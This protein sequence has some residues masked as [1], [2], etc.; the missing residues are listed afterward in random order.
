MRKTRAVRLLSALMPEEQKEFKRY[1]S[2]P[3]FN[4]SSRQI[5]ATTLLLK[6]INVPD[7]LLNKSEL[8]LKLFPDLKN[9]LK[10]LSESKMNAFIGQKLDP[11]LSQLKTHIEDFLIWKAGRK[12]GF[13]RNNAL[14]NDLFD[15]GNEDLY[16]SY[17]HKAEQQLDAEERHHWQYHHFKY[18]LLIGRY[19]LPGRDRIDSAQYEIEKAQSHLDLYFTAEKLNKAYILYGMNLLYNTS[20]QVELLDPIMDFARNVEAEHE[21]H[22]VSY[23]FLLRVLNKMKPDQKEFDEF[24]TIILKYIDS[25]PEKDHYGIFNAL[26]NYLTFFHILQN[27]DVSAEIYELMTIGMERGYLLEK[28]RLNYATMVNFVAAACFAKKYE[29]AEDWLTRYKHTLEESFRENTYHGA[30]AHIYFEAGRFRDCLNQLNKKT[31]DVNVIDKF[32]EKILRLKC[33]YELAEFG[34]LETTLDATRKQFER[35]KD[36]GPV[37]ASSYGTFL[38][39]FRQIYRL[40]SEQHCS[41][42]LIEI[43]NQGEN[44]DSKAWL[45]RKANELRN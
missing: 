37:Y 32:R 36:L 18:M 8:F 17:S 23:Y 7:F 44:S 5:K 45:L 24:K 13:D 22:I 31:S 10:A 19:N 1:I 21:L 28:G 14:V 6:H 34:I 2:S 26:Q 42:E 15:R 11:L 25:Y 41:R 40:R 12:P 33:Y 20:Y 38:K 3:F 30:L 4:R 39:Y 16:L 43:L 29:E 9:D 27:N 35:T